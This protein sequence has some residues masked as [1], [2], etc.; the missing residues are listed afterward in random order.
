[1]E[2]AVADDNAA[3]ELTADDSALAIATTELADSTAELV[4]EELEESESALTV[5]ELESELES[6]SEVESELEVELELPL[7][8]HAVPFWPLNCS[9]GITGG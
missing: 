4:A 3:E 1:M 5:L 7:A 6:E 8:V 9:G 2:L